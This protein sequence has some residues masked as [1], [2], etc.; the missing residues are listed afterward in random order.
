MRI[1][2]TDEQVTALGYALAA[3]ESAY[4]DDPPYEVPDKYSSEDT[5]RCWNGY[6]TRTNAEID[7]L[8]AVAEKLGFYPIERLENANYSEAV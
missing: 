1:Y 7:I 5:V 2:L 8:N 4:V 3:Y 6:V